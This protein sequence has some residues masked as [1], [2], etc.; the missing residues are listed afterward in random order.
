MDDILA[1]LAFA[2]LIGG[3][4]LAAIVVISKRETIYGISRPDPPAGPHPSAIQCQHC[5]SP[6]VALASLAI[7]QRRNGVDVPAPGTA[8]TTALKTPLPQF[9]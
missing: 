8:A 7:A 5:T 9:D 6:E 4:F 3:Q 2:L 1:P